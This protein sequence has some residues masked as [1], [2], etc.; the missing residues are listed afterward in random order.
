MKLLIIL[1]AVTAFCSLS[2]RQRDIDLH[3]ALYL[4]ERR[5]RHRHDELDAAKANWHIYVGENH[6]DVTPEAECATVLERT[7]IQDSSGRQA[8]P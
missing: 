8:S 5:A 4:C 3:A 6:I 7:L 2:N 1:T